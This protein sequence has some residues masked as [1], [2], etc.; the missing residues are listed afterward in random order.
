MRLSAKITALE[1]A[2]C[3]C[4]LSQTKRRKALLRMAHKYLQ[5]RPAYAYYLSTGTVPASFY[6]IPS[7]H[8]LTN[9]QPRNDELTQNLWEY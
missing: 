6:E 7:V 1:V 3:K 2:C 5:K 8:I 9:N 4:K